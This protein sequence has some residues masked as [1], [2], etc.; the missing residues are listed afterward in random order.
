MDMLNKTKVITITLLS[1]F[2]S[3]FSLNTYADAAKI[4]SIQVK[5][6]PEYTRV[7]FS[8]DGPTHYHVFALANPDRLGVDFDDARLKINLNALD[9][10]DSLITKARS[11]RPKAGVLRIVFDMQGHTKHKNSVVQ[12][13]KVSQLVMDVYS[14]SA[15]VSAP[16]S[17]KLEKPK[18]QLVSSPVFVP[19]IKTV[20]PDPIDALPKKLSSFAILVPRPRMVIVAIDAG[21]GGKD[22]GT[23]GINGTKEKDVVLDI[24]REL[25]ALINKEP[26]MH[27]VLTRNGDYFVSLRDRLRRAREYRADLF[28]AIHADSYL[29]NRSAG[30]SVYTLSSHGAS[31]EA[32]RWL[33]RREN[34]SELGSVELDGLSDKSSL[35]RSVL[36]DLAQTATI[37][38]SIRFGSSTLAA[39]Q[40]VTTLHYTRVEQ[41][42]FMVLKSPDIP[43]ILVETGFLSNPQEERRLRDDVYRYKLAGA[44][45]VG[46]K[47]YFTDHSQVAS[48]AKIVPAVLKI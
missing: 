7:I 30:A 29:D 10:A 8:I 2:F 25:A 20:V 26:S 21:H 39:L 46:V 12:N 19:T 41:A 13:G 3:L 15:S 1:L 4:T 36:I 38:D 48:N 27:A 33:A 34:Y 32:A 18:A 5:K 24:A 44:L 31:T 16:V 14:K 9:F 6:F 22:P 45:L 42:P 43:S 37:N 47:R 11:G 28:I 23:I 35:L 17:V 40:K